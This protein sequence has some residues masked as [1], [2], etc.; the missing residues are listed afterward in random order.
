MEIGRLGMMPMSA[1]SRRDNANQSE[2]E[3]VCAESYQARSVAEN[4]H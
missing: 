1:P 2:A 4:H 3:Q